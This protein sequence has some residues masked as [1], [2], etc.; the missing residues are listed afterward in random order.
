LFRIGCAKALEA[1][2]IL[3]PV[4][5][6][7]IRGRHRNHLKTAKKW[8]KFAT[9]ASRNQK[10]SAKASPG[11]NKNGAHSHQLWEPIEINIDKPAWIVQ[12]ACTLHPK[13]QDAFL[14]HG[15]LTICYHAISISGYI[16]QSLHTNLHTFTSPG[17]EIRQNKPE[18][19]KLDPDKL[20]YTFWKPRL[21]PLFHSL[22]IKPTE[23]QNAR[24]QTQEM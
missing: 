2:E 12:E 19:S 16:S 15:M 10:G 18:E 11:K 4:G 23:C 14:H 5:G 13:I 20:E 3:P 21:V 22:Q 17:D 7:T 8:L 24:A 1:C 6:R 9:K